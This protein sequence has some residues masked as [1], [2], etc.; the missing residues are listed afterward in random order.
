MVVQR[1]FKKKKKSVFHYKPVDFGSGSE[2]SSREID[3]VVYGT[4]REHHC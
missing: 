4:G 2:R 1:K 3:D